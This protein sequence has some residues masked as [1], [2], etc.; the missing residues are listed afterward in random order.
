M[1]TLVIF[2]MLLQAKTLKNIVIMKTI[3]NLISALILILPLSLLHGN[4][5]YVV[6]TE[7]SLI[8]WEG[9]RIAGTTHTGT[10]NVKEGQVVFDNGRFQGGTFTIDMSTIN[11]T[12]L[13]GARKERLDGHLKNEDF[14]DVTKFPTSTLVITNVQRADDGRWRI[15]GDITIKNITRPITFFATMTLTD[16]RLVAVANLTFN[17]SDFDVRFGS[18]SF[19]DNLGDRAIINDIPLEITLVA[20][21]Q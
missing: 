6:D 13:E 2:W 4:T 20:N 16:D 8:N 3:K 18:N 7:N 15:T 12:D 11:T 17:R 9:R 5:V 10:I 1:K 21:R 14:F 19:F